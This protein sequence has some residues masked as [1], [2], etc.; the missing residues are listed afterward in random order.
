MPFSPPSPV[1]KRRQSAAFLLLLVVSLGV[2]ALAHAQAPPLPLDPTRNLPPAPAPAHTT[3]PE[4]YIWTANDVTALRPDHGRF[5]WNRPDLRVDPHR[6]RVHFRVG[7]L[8]RVAT[9]Y[10]AGPRE[11]HIFL[12]GRRLDDFYLDTDAPIGFHVFHTSVAAALRLGDN[13][14]AIEATRGHGIVTGAAS[15]ATQQLTY[16]EIIVARIA[17]AQFGVEAPALVVSNGTWRSATASP[18]HPQERWS[19]PG[20]DDSSWQPVESLGPVESNVDFF[21]WSA[22]AGMYEWPG[23]VG[24]S[25]GL[26]TF[27][28]PASAVTH[29]FSGA[30]SFANLASLTSATSTATFSITNTIGAQATDAD[31]P[32]IL[33]D[34]GRE[35]TGRLLVESASPADATLSIA[36]GESE[37]EAL[38]TGLTPGQQG[39]NYLGTN[40]LHVPANGVARGPKSG[41]RYVRIRFL[42]GAPVTAYKSIRVEGIYDPVAYAGSFVSSDPLLNR[43]WETG[44]YTA[45]L[46]MQDGIWDAPKRDRGR[47]AGDLDI[48]GHVI[49]TVFGDRAL[50]E[51]TLRALVPSAGAHVNGIPSYSA[52][53]ITSLADLYQHFGDIAFLLSQRQALLGILAGM[54]ASLNAD[55][56]FDNHAHQWLF[57]DWAPGLYAYTPESRIGTQLQYI[58]AY[59]AAAALLRALDDAA[60]GQRYDAQATRALNAIHALRDANG[61][62]YGDT[63]QLNAL[64]TVVDDPKTAGAI[65]TRVLSH[66]KQDAPADQVVSPYFNAYVLEAMD[67]TGHQQQAL[68]W[69]RAYWGGMLAEGATSFWE[70]YDLRWP[71]T[72]PQLSLQADGTS[73]Y[74][75]SLAHGWSSGPTAWLTENVLGITPSS[76]AYDTV[77]IRPRLL[78][79]DYAGGTVPT[80][81]GTIAIHIDRQKGIDLDLP[82]GIARATVAYYASD[83]TR[84]VFLDGKPSR[85]ENC[86]DTQQ[87][88]EITQAG[89]HVIGPR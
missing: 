47:W 8:P 48:E 5:P 33:L 54:D 10:V 72:N 40:L 22:D 62:T 55:G 2:G 85:C 38:A 65:W 1:L 71:K 29:I 60:A 77:D 86:K 83:P 78:G 43:I 52:L 4:E 82:P 31:A 84:E 16:G 57:V 59:H 79:L 34:F 7:A 45:H 74:F 15:T 36:Y 73:G 24:M 88:F 12:N 35:V 67:V 51:E 6:F 30:A 19:E 53:W 70:S 9:L 50:T 3:L 26:R 17:P 11:A 25:P 63:W 13:V 37:I 58:R 75:V 20:F 28:L 44:A 41:F 89:H 56:L 76:P 32:S 81:H 27:A 61:A 69:I 46:C 87:V 80:P 68:D 42:R 39:G 66:V 49:S 23:Y 14:L 21:Q 64:A 18:E